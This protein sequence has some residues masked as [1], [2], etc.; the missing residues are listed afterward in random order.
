MPF[1]LETIDAQLDQLRKSRAV[2]VS[3]VVVGSDT[4]ET[5]F[6]TD[7]EMAGAEAALLQQRA[8]L[9]GTAVTTIRVAA[10]KGLDE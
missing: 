10:S 5:A 7:A 6:K 8:A 2:G 9:T 3:R 1:D 4:V